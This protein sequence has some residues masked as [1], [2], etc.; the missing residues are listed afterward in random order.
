M[1][2]TK[3]EILKKGKADTPPKKEVWN[4]ETDKEPEVVKLNIWAV[5]LTMDT[6]ARER[7]DEETVET[8][9]QIYAGEIEK[10]TLPPIEVVKDDISLSY[11]IIDGN[12][13]LR[14]K[15]LNSKIYT[16]KDEIF[17]E[18]FTRI[19]AII[20]PRLYPN[21]RAQ[22]EALIRSAEANKTHGLPR[23]IGDKRRAVRILL[24][25]SKDQAK[26]SDSAIAVRAGVSRE[27][28]KSVR[29][30]MEEGGQRQTRKT[31][32]ERAREVIADPENENKSNREL[33]KMS[34]VSEGTI[35]VMKKAKEQLEQY[36]GNQEENANLEKTQ[37][38]AAK[39]LKENA[40]EVPKA[41]PEERDYQRRPTLLK[42]TE[43]T[44]RKPAPPLP[45]KFGIGTSGKQPDKKTKSEEAMEAS[46][47][48]R[49]VPEELIQTVPLNLLDAAVQIKEMLGHYEGGARK[50]Y[51]TGINTRKGANPKKPPKQDQWSVQ[52]RDGYEDQDTLMIEIEQ[53]GADAAKWYDWAQDY[54]YQ[55]DAP[56][57]EP[58]T[59][60]TSGKAEKTKSGAIPLKDVENLSQIVE[61]IYEW[62]GDRVGAFTVL[63]MDKRNHSN[64]ETE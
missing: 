11:W 49:N 33:A 20:R 60:E 1:A 2:K 48:K 26:V 64:E 23:S 35:R 54:I 19:D 29:K 56:A 12:H 3:Q 18:K 39:W 57:A 53:Q 25:A 37:A 22:E 43:E 10:A 21:L 59:K 7:M 36:Q 31:P 16:K 4:Q 14:A 6:Q 58:E 24:N 40:V 9:R 52:K 5:K 41:D 46:L 51:H 8:Y 34:G 27:L 17:S 32:A 55:E 15:R 45:S 61:D 63:F 13:R 42:I 62:L 47:R 38:A 44:K 30:E 28:V 50:E